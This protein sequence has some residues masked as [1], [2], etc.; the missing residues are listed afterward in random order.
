MVIN[1]LTITTHRVKVIDITF[2]FDED[3]NVAVYRTSTR[4]VGW[5]SFLNPLKVIHIKRNV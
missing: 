5:S 1:T 2:P 4:Y 3:T